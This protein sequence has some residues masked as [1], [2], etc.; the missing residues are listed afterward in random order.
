MLTLR[1]ATGE[2]VLASGFFEI[3]VQEITSTDVQLSVHVTRATVLNLFTWGDERWRN[4]TPE[5]PASF[6]VPWGTNFRIGEVL[7]NVDRVQGKCKVSL[8]AP[9]SIRFTRPAQHGGRLQ[10]V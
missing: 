1:I 10:A 6:R 8:A 7:V 2:S 9:K 5:L 4:L 3:F